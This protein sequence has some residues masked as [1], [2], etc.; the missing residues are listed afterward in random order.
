MVC[1]GSLLRLKLSS[2]FQRTVYV[3][4]KHWSSSSVV[5]TLMNASSNMMPPTSF[6]ENTLSGDNIW[7]INLINAL[8]AHSMWHN[9][10][11]R[12]KSPT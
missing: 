11:G 9:Y 3:Y 5:W 1:C 10:Q 7:P 6:N 8:V 12:S 4:T 2:K